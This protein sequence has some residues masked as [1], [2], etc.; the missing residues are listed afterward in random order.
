MCAWIFT[1]KSDRWKRV[2][3]DCRNNRRRKNEELRS[4]THTLFTGCRA[5]AQMKILL[6]S[7]KKHTILSREIFSFFVSFFYKRKVQENDAKNAERREEKKKNYLRTGPV[8][9]EERNDTEK[10]THQSTYGLFFR[11]ACWWWSICTIRWQMLFWIIGG[12]MW[13]LDLMCIF[14]SSSIY[15]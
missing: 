4:T 11:G 9:W 2:D 1:R 5:L 13:R 7:I 8:H 3:A 6:L 15:A 10:E 12:R 14:R